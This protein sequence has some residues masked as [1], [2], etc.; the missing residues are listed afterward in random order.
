M[1]NNNLVDK[2]KK[3]SSNRPSNWKKEAKYRIENKKWLDYTA[4]IALRIDAII[5][6][7]K[8]LN[9]V[10]LAKSLKMPPQQ[11]SR[12]LRGDQNLTL[13]TIGKLSDAIGF[14]LISFPPYKDTYIIL[15]SAEKKV[16]FIYQDKSPAEREVKNAFYISERNNPYSKYTT[17]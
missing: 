6:D 2:L 3:I 15:Q 10:S 12:I 7:N 8:E 4:Q 1:K 9:Q 14:E 16:E 5:E 11:I 13:K 17:I